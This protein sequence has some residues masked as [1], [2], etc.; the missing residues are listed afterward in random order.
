[1]AWFLPLEILRGTITDERHEPT[2]ILVLFRIQGSMMYQSLGIKQHC[3]CDRCCVQCC[4]GKDFL[5]LNFD[6]C[7]NRNR[8]TLSWLWTFWYKRLYGSIWVPITSTVRWLR[9]N[10]RFMASVGDVSICMSCNCNP[11]TCCCTGTALVSVVLFYVVVAF[12]FVCVL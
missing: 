1:M 9:N 5:M 4:T 12:E 2:M 6:C 8:D 10:W 7:G 11:K 3:S